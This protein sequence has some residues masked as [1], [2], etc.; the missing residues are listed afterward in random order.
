MFISRGPVRRSRI[1]PLLCEPFAGPQTAFKIEQLHQ[2]DYRPAPVQSRQV[3]PRPARGGAS[4][5]RLLFRNDNE[6][7]GIAATLHAGSRPSGNSRER[8][9][10]RSS[11][12]RRCSFCNVPSWNDAA[13]Q[14]PPDNERAI[15]LNAFGCGLVA[16]TSV[17]YGT[18]DQIRT[19]FATKL[20][21]FQKRL[22]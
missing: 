5:S 1:S 6:I 9:V 15:S 22:N 20:S 11:R 3:L 7:I 12:S 19:G 10:T 2:I 14:P 8:T 17:S 4:H 21:A 13:R 16:F 18:S